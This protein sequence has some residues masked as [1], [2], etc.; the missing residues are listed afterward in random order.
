[1]NNNFKK[2]FMLLLI[3]IIIIIISIISILLLLSKGKSKNVDVNISTNNI[4]NEENNTD[5]IL[6][7][8]D[9]EKFFTVAR[10]I[11]ESIGDN[12]Y[13]VPLKMNWK[14]GTD[15]DLY[16]V[17]GIVMDKNYENCQYVYYV[18]KLDSFNKIYS[19]KL[20]DGKYDDVD[21][22]SLLYRG[23]LNEG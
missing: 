6:K 18:V 23:S 7:V 15:L 8:T 16:S 2:G 21:E 4:D 10:C 17:Y 20:L 12:Y 1:M 22:S 5:V 3:L 11:S 14:E 9:N 19:V 13:F